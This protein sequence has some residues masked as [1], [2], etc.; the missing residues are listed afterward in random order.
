MGFRHWWLSSVSGHVPAYYVS[1][2]TWFAHSM[3]CTT[4]FISAIMMKKCSVYSRSK[5]WCS[6]PEL[7]KILKFASRHSIRHHHDDIW[8][9]M[10]FSFNITIKSNK[11]LLMCWLERWLGWKLDHVGVTLTRLHAFW[12][13]GR[14]I[15]WWLTQRMPDLEWVTVT[16][17]CSPPPMLRRLLFSYSPPLFLPLSFGSHKQSPLHLTLSDFITKPYIG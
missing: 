3:V 5:A 1:R 12:A 2:T 11:I 14:E 9:S 16:A 6:K 4:C 15:C 13:S 7:A 10:S 8:S 17:S